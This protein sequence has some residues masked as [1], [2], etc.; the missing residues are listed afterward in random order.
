MKKALILIIFVVH[1]VGCVYSKD[2]HFIY[3]V[4]DKTMQYEL[5]NDKLSKL[6]YE[7]DN[8]GED[9]VLLYSNAYPKLV[10][11]K[12]S[13]I[14]SIK[15]QIANIA[16]YTAIDPSDELSKFVSIFQDKEI[17]KVE[18]DTTDNQLSIKPLGMYHS[19]VF[20][21]FV[22]DSFFKQGFHNSLLAKFLFASDL[23]LKDFNVDIIYYNS[24][25]IL[26]DLTKVKF[27]E[28]YNYNNIKIFLK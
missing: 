21:V 15:L 13:E 4:V 11:D 26:L 19:I 2:F 24:S 8:E 28:L 18:K 1:F 7:I 12:V 5:I 23:H 20:D 27:N 16:T 3:I 10:V 14:E 22:G 17:C 9:F 25:S 6:I